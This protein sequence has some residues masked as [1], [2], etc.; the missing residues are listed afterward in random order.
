MRLCG[1][2]ILR[3]AAFSAYMPEPAPRALRVLRLK[4]LFLLGIHGKGPPREHRERLGP[5]RSEAI[6]LAWG[7]L[8]GDCRVAGAP[9]GPVSLAMTGF[10]A[11]TD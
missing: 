6:S 8:S 2:K 1:R 9:L 11:K 7:T 10:R 3:N 5:K 4:R